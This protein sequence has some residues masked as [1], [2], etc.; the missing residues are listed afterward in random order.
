MQISWS[1]GS[2]IRNVSGFGDTASQVYS[3][4]AG[5]CFWVFRLR[6]SLTGPSWFDGARW[7]DCHNFCLSSQWRLNSGVNGCECVIVCWE[8]P[9]LA[10]DICSLGF[11]PRYSSFC[12]FKN[13]FLICGQRMELWKRVW[14]I[15]RARL[16]NMPCKLRL[17]ASVV[18]HQ[19]TLPCWVR[20][21][22]SEGEL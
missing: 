21:G 11:F 13:K 16:S 7:L 12:F 18:F 5:W 3:G 15:L 14:L 19:I 10:R 20:A 1:T 8:L 22:D 17:F 6:W 4:C 2:V 9:L